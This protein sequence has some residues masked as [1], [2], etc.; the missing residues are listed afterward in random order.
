[1]Q[2]PCAWS[3]A[4]RSCNARTCIEA[5][6][7]LLEVVAAAAALA[8]ARSRAD[9]VR[10][11]LDEVQVPGIAVCDLVLCG[12]LQAL[13]QQGIARLLRQHRL[14]AACACLLLLLLLPL[15]VCMAGECIR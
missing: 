13:L 10:Q 7:H 8:P 9:N 5:S 14:A 3:F 2:S 15:L 12:E 6:A 4:T 11:V 1:M